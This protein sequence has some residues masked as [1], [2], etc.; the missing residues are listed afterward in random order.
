[1]TDK[2]YISVSQQVRQAIADYVQITVCTSC[3]CYVWDI[4]AHERRCND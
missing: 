3:G 2:K 4:Q 1:M